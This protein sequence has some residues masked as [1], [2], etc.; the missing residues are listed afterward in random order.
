MPIAV[1]GTDDVGGFFA[2]GCSAQS[3]DPTPKDS[4]PKDEWGG[5]WG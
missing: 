1:F 2:D 3:Y 5:H 4:C